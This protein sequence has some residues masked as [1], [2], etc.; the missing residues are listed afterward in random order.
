M[1]NVSVRRELWG[2]RLHPKPRVKLSGSSSLPDQSLRDEVWRPSLQWVC[3][4]VLFL[5]LQP[6]DAF[7]RRIIGSVDGAH[8]AGAQ[9]IDDLILTDG[10]KR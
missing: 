4:A 9:R 5:E 3:G 2:S 1:L 8:S 6:K 7:E 10:R